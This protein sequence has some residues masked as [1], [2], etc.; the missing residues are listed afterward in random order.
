MNKHS[1]IVISGVGQRL[2]F[3]LARAF[4]NEGYHVIGTYRKQRDELKQLSCLGAELYCCDF[5][6][7]DQVDGFISA[8]QKQHQQLRAIIHNASEWLDD[9][10]PWFEVMDKMMKVHVSSP[11]QISMQLAPLLQASDS[12]FADIIHISDYVASTGSKK[13]AAYAASK[14]AVDNLSLSLAAKFAPKIKVNSIAPS[15]IQFNNDDGENYRERTLKKS[16]I[17]SEAG[18]AEIKNSVSY[19]LGSAYI[20]GSIVTVNGGRHICRQSC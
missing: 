15:L 16:L 12:D 4:L 17:P 1:S 8:V 7:G 10:Q 18:Y 5:Y 13:H 3:F 14:A 19:L 20:T 2:G 6:I 11:F 9:R